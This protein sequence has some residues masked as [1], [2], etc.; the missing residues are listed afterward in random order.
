VVVE[1]SSVVFAT[2]DRIRR[3]LRGTV[4]FSFALALLLGIGLAQTMAAPLARLRD[5]VLEVADGR[6]GQQVST[7]GGGELT[8]LAQAFNVMSTRLHSAQAEVDEKQERIERFNRELQ[9][10][11]DERTAE[12]RE[13]QGDLVRSG[14]LAAVVEVGAGL[15]H[16]LNNPLAGILGLTQLMR[17]RHREGLD[18]SLLVDIESQAQRCR[19][20]VEAMQRFADGDVDPASKGVVN[21]Q[22]LLADVKAL[23]GGP[24]RQRGVE[25]KLYPPEA[26]LTVGLD[27]LQG[28][29]LFTQILHS[30][31]AGLSA[32]TTLSVQVVRD[33]D[34]ASVTFS[35][36]RSVAAT[37]SRAD[38][39]RAAGLGLWVARQ[40]A[41]RNGGSLDPVD[42]ET[43]WLL[44]LPI[45][46]EGAS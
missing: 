44:R 11:V 14:Q 37:L 29:R 34:L 38:D 10:R 21:L 8:E 46:E 33:G 7:S 19:E 18:A 43:G 6:F 36:D 40:L 28:A 25:L 9:E 12:L 16:E 45:V 17:T 1:P 23:V 24:F 3:T 20:V 2:A 42:D 41:D 32:G 5:S 15:A 39:Q 35:S 22:A 13:A 4:A 27:P 30:L 31:R 26:P